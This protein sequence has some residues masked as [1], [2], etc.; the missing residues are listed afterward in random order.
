[1]NVLSFA[2]KNIEGLNSGTLGAGV[3]KWRKKKKN[4]NNNAS[5]IAVSER[6]LS[7]RMGLV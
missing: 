2:S 6:C 7:H 1:V 4:N 3:S 5:F